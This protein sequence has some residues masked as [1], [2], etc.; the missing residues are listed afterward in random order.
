MILCITN[1]NFNLTVLFLLM[2][3]TQVVSHRHPLANFFLFVVGCCC[4]CCCSCFVFVKCTYVII[5]QLRGEYTYFSASKLRKALFEMLEILFFSVKHDR[6][7]KGCFLGKQ[8]FFFTWSSDL[9][10]YEVKLCDL[11]FTLH[12]ISCL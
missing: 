9:P 1:V 12:L 2:I 11:D 3:I 4:C 10:C 8:C 5:C 6:N 7:L